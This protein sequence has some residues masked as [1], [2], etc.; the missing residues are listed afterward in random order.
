[1]L[2]RYAAPA[3]EPLTLEE[4]KIHLRV[5]DGAEDTLIESLIKA[6]RSSIDGK[7]GWLNRALITQT[8]DLHLDRFPAD[9]RTPIQI[10]LPPLQSVTHVKYY[11][12]DGILQ[13]LSSANYFVDSVSEPARLFPAYNLS[14]PTTRERPN[15]VNVRFVA[16]YGA[17]AGSIPEAIRQ[18][19]L[20][21]IGHWYANRESVAV[22]V[23]VAEMPQ[24]VGW[25]LRPY[26]IYQESC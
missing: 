23:S 5:D 1:M 16:G 6:F 12:A 9:S 26:K 11:D 19:G 8:W 18:A 21:Q 15:A 13:T 14:W 7:D 10:P 22:G 3:V 4:A 17:A 24:S 2:V 25:L 20:L